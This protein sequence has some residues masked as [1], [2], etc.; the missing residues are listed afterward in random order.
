MIR[1]CL[2]DSFYIG[3]HRFYISEAIPEIARIKLAISMFE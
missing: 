3:K 1:N 2:G